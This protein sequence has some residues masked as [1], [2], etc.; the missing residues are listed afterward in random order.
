MPKTRFTRQVEQVKMAAGAK[1]P[2]DHKKTNTFR[3]FI[4]MQAP[5]I[6]PPLDSHHL[7][8]RSFPRFRI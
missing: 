6:A 8:N 2:S 3:R 5:R 4:R 1:T 7:S